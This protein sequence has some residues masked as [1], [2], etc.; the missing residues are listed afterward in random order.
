MGFS[1]CPACVSAGHHGGT[2][3]YQSG[4]Y[5]ARDHGIDQIRRFC[6]GFDQDVADI[7]V[8]QGRIFRVADLQEFVKI[9]LEF[10]D[11]HSGKLHVAISGRVFHFAGF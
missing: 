9:R 5:A 4:L 7:H 11:A 6:F 10:F 2:S 1:P 8:I 3:L